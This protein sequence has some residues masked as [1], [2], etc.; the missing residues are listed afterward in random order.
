MR[1][2]L[3]GRQSELRIVGFDESVRKEEIRELLTEYGGCEY[4]EIS[5]GNIRP[6]R[7]GMHMTWAQCPLAIAIKLTNQGKIKLGWTV[8]K[9]ELLEAKPKQCYKCWE[10]GHTK[11]NCHLKI[12][13]SNLCFKCGRPDHSYKDCKNELHCVLCA[14]QGIDA[15]HRIGSFRCKTD[16]KNVRMNKTNSYRI[17]NENARI[18]REVAIWNYG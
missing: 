17:R 10:F 13:R 14:Q 1:P 16:K 8:A 12:D 11:N 15:K 4:E 2:K 18:E 3:Q 5:I 9:I 7:N 6:M